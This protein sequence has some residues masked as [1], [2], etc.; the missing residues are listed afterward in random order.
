MQHFQNILVG[1]D[2]S[3]GDRL[4]SDELNDSTEEAIESSLRVAERFNG[5]L[6][7]FAAVEISAQT[8]ELMEADT[9]RLT[10]SVDDD[11]RDVLANI[12]TRA[13]QRGIPAETQFAHGTAWEAIIQKVVRDQHDLVIIGTKEQSR[14]G[15]MLFGSTGVKLIRHCPCPVWLTK[16]G[17]RD[18]EIGNVLVT[19]DLGEVGYEG[20]RIAIMGGREFDVRTLVL[21]VVDFDSG[22]WF[23]GTANPEEQQKKLQERITQAERQLQERLAGLDYRTLEHGVQTF[24]RSGNT[25]EEIVKMIDE[26]DV[27][28][29]I[30]GT[31]ERT[32]LGAILMGSMTERLLPRIKCSLLAIKPKEFICEIETQ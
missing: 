5:K 12:K 3:S 19:D 32:G 27:D 26:H 16:P 21:H 1:V 6:T 23:R 20:L 2:L 17:M 15:R 8:A 29:L 9:E 28:L 13:D 14:L 4:A 30:M 18:R 25:D 31:H 10:H 24:V 7:F 22:S 11:V